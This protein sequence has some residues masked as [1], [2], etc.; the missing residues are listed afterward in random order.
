MVGR[1]PQGKLSAAALPMDPVPCKT[2]VGAV[3]LTV[4]V[5]AVATLVVE[6]H[7]LAV[8]RV[9]TVELFTV[10]R[11]QVSVPVVTAAWQLPTLLVAEVEPEPG[12]NVS[13]KITPETGSPVL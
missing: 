13:V 8:E 4:T 9:V 11:V 1:L 7:L 3:T 10:P 2:V 12:A 6:L 5:A